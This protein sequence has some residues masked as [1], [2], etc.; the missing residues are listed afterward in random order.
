MPTITEQELREMWNRSL[1]IMK[2]MHKSDFEN[3]SRYDLCGFIGAMKAELFM[4]GIFDIESP[5]DIAHALADKD[6]LI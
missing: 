1:N 4:K 2:E 3:S 5:V 6:K